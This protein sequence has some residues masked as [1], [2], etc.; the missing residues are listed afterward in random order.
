M[1]Y[2]IINR[3]D[4]VS[5]ALHERFI[6]LA[7]QY[8]L[9]LD[10]EQ[11][12]TVLSI[13]GDGT[14]LQAFHRYKDQLDRLSFVGLHTGRLGFFADWKPE[15]LDTMA[16]VMARPPEE[17]PHSFVEYPLLSIELHTADGME[18]RLALNE[19]TIKGI[20]E[21]MVARL[22]VNDV[23]FETFRG[24]GICISSPSGSTAYNK[25]LGGA[26]IHPSIPC[27]QITEIASI[28]NRVFRTVGSPLV[29]PKHHHCDIYPQAGKR[30]SFSLDHLG[31]Q[32]DNLVSIRTS[33]A[34]ETIRFARYRPYPF[35]SRVQR[36]FIGQEPTEF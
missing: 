9:T 31:F 2:F 1:K 23:I 21:T 24:D 30:M 17:H 3:G 29:L 8:G 7:D 19:F 34:K 16:R 20:E 6:R 36:A 28:N 22:D 15:E 33:V 27:L 12:D 14:M 26:V 4:E 18:S 32:R 13:G 5:Q 10:E 25:S 11:P 35:W